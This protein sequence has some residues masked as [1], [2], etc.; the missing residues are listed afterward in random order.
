MDEGCKNLSPTGV[1]GGDCEGTPETARIRVYALKDY[2]GPHKKL[3]ERC[4]PTC[5]ATRLFPRSKS[6]QAGGGPCVRTQGK[7]RTRLQLGG[8]WPDAENSAGAGCDHSCDGGLHRA[9]PW[10]TAR[11]E[12]GGLHAAGR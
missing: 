9:A 3:P 8:R 4:F 1:V 11:S 10:R 5:C 2:A 12:L 6:C 7:G